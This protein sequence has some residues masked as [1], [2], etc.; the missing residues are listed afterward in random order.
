MANDLDETTG[1]IDREGRDVNVISKQI[2]VQIGTGSLVFEIALW[3]IGTIPGV[4]L[5]ANE[6]LQKLVS[7]GILISGALPGLIFLFMK[8]NA[9]ADL[10]KLQQKIQAD[11]S[12]ID[13]YLEQRVVILLTVIEN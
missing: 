7:V 12:Q 10:R 4:V 9:L 3:T 8:I 2:P 5:L 1:P 6:V 11:A 13:A